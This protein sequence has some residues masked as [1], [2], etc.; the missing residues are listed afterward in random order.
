MAVN[1][2]SHQYE[3]LNRLHDAISVNNVESN[4]ANTG[5]NIRKDEGA[6]ITLYTNKF[7]H[8]ANGNIL[9][10]LRNDGANP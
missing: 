6:P 4:P 3:Q 2:Y 10:P 5:Y 9:R 7:V 1:G 8:G